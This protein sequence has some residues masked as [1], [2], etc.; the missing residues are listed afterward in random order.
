MTGQLILAEPWPMERER[1]RAG[2]KGQMFR[3]PPERRR[4]RNGRGDHRPGSTTTPPAKHY[5]ALGGVS[6]FSSVASQLKPRRR[7]TPQAMSL[8]GTM[9]R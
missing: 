8:S 6:T 5:R 7:A 9:L 3:Q 4:T 2:H 1:G